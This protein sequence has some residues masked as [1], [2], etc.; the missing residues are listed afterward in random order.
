VYDFC[1]YQQTDLSTLVLEESM[2]AD[3]NIDDSAEEEARKCTP[4]MLD[5][6]VCS[7]SQCAGDNGLCRKV[8]ISSW[9]EA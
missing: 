2:I 4:N 1:V 7:D 3:E 6:P 9:I 5:R 8:S